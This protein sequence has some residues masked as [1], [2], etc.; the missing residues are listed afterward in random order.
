MTQLPEQ[1]AVTLRQV[2]EYVPQLV[3]ANAARLPIVMVTQ[4]VMFVVFAVLAVLTY[5]VVRSFPNDEWG[6]MDGRKVFGIGGAVVLGLV[7]LALL[8]DTLALASYLGSPEVWAL[9]DL[10]AAVRRQ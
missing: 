8:I 1:A 6:S 7:G 3:A 5:R 10:L 9:K 4:V 2:T